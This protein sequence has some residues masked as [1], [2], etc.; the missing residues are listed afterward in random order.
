[1]SA[2]AFTECNSNHRSFPLCPS[3]RVARVIPSGGFDKQ[4]KGAQRRSFTLVLLIKGARVH[5]RAARNAAGK[6][7]SPLA[8]SRE[9]ASAF[10]L[11]F[12]EAAVG[13]ITAFA[14]KGRC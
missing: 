11:A 1:M 4:Y 8:P 5:K 12:K 9:E 2:F 10:D 3:R 7:E 13:D 6:G 14:F